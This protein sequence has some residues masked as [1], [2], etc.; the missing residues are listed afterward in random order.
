MKE[1]AIL[2]AFERFMAFLLEKTAGNLPVWL[3]PE[4]LRFITVNQEETTIAFAQKLANQAQELGIRSEVDNSNESVGKKIR[5]SELMKT[6]YTV[7]I[8]EK[9]IESSTIT[10]RIRKDLISDGHE[11]T[12][13]S[14]DVFLATVSDE[15][16]S[17]ASKTSL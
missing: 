11:D 10:P 12:S 6:P 3:A 7:V 1:A 8:G 5:E 14:I 9:E 13:L 2:G 17:R 4:Q 16:K 15:A